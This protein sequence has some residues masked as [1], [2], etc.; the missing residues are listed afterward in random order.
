MKSLFIGRWQPFHDGHKQLID[1]VINEGNDVVIAIR[2]T[3]ISDEN[4]YTVDERKKMIENVYGDKVDVITIPD[5]GEVCYGRKVGYNIRE[6]RLSEDVES[7][8]GTKIR[9]KL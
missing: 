5:I 1:T 9:S 8:S 4:P 6:I 2:D 3:Q 7:I